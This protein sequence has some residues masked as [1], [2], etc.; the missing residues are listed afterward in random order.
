MAH[1]RLPPLR[2]VLYD[3]ETAPLRPMKRILIVSTWRTGSSFLGELISSSPGVF[4]SYE[5]LNF[6]THSR[7][8]M[9]LIH[10]LFQCNFPEDYVDSLNAK[11]DFLMRN[12]RLWESCHRNKNQNQT[13]CNRPEFLRIL[14]AHS[15]VQLIKVVRLRIQDLK[16]EDDWKIIYLARDPRGVVASRTNLTWCQEDPACGDIRRLCS[17]MEADVNALSSKYLMIRF[18]DLTLNMEIETE[19]LFKY[20]EMP[21][22]SSVR[23]FLETHTKGQRHQKSDLNKDDDPFSTHRDS[24]SVAYEWRKKLS[25]DRIR[26]IS[27]TCSSVLKLLDYPIN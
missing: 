17:E 22:T 16:P 10:S 2:P 3:P 15:P 24:K 12:R 13:L 27:E 26:Q 7:S 1:R 23:L 14:C 5:P 18:E 9:D 8:P 6:P 11:P 20:L 19:R 25:K 21:L 4:Y